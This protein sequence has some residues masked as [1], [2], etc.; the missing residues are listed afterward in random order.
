MRQHTTEQRLICDIVIIIIIII[1]IYF[2]QD[3]IK[4]SNMTIHEQ[5]RHY[6][7]IMSLVSNCVYIVYR[8][9]FNALCYI[10][11]IN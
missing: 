5:D 7:T 1:I 4:P 9:P 2:A 3:T 10:M 11:I 6:E 8:H